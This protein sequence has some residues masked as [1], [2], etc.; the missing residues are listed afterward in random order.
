SLNTFDEPPME[1][2]AL[3]PG[4]TNVFQV[5][6]RQETVPGLKSLVDRPGVQQTLQAQARAQQQNETD[7]EL[8]DHEQ[9]AK[10]GPP[11][12]AAAGFLLERGRGNEP[13]ASCRRHDPENHPGENR[14]Q[15]GESN[16]S[17]VNR[18]IKLNG[19]HRD[20]WFQT[21]EQ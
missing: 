21:Q 3:G 10:T 12:A 14:E 9:A 4:V 6:R 13:G 2:L 8:R 16:D 7:G 18:D 5:E 19:E 17:R 20:G 15:Q 11:L 1:L